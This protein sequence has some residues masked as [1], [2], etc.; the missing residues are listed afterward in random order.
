MGTAVVKYVEREDVGLGAACGKPWLGPLGVVQAGDVGKKC[1]WRG[2][3]QVEND[4]QFKARLAKEEAAKV[5]PTTDP[6]YI[7]VG[8]RLARHV[9]SRRGNHSEAHMSELELAAVLAVAAE[10][11]HQLDKEPS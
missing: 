3:W 7:E 9:F 8:K 11:G 6:R 10:K 5:K 2:V 4:E 1:M